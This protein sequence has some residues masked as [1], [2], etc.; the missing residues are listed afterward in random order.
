MSRLEQVPSLK[1]EL[2]VECVP[3]MKLAQ[4]PSSMDLDLGFVPSM[5][6]AQLPLSMDLDLGFVPSL[7]QELVIF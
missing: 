6:L 4:L 5:K 7:K 1:Q 2:G 3:S